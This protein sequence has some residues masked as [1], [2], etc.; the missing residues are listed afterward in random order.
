MIVSAPPPHVKRST[1]QAKGKGQRSQA[2]SRI[3]QLPDRRPAS[4]VADAV[5]S[6]LHE[7]RTPIVAGGDCTIAVGAVSGFLRHDGD[8]ALLYMDGGVDIAT[9]ANYRAGVL[10]STGV[11][12]MVAERGTAEALSR[13][14]PR[15]PL[16]PGERIVPF[17]YTPGEP[18]D[19]ENEI[20][21]RHSI[22]GYP[23]D[24]VRG[25]AGDAAAEALAVLEG[26][27]GGFLVH[28]DVDVID[29]V[30][31]PVADV[32]QINAG[33]TFADAMEALHVFVSS[34]RFG[35]LVITEL[36]PDHAD[37]EGAAGRALVDGVVRA[38]AGTRA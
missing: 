15:F 34:P 12:H 27:T 5:A 31:L 3:R 10:D 7:G 20:L 9:P 8:L 36:S 23:A 24:R 22:D 17:G 1:P 29:F 35:G 26:K 6:T 14:G 25:R 21:G 18:L 30:D 2:R 11:A 37:E 38:L 19:A 4:G 28:F 32:P 33:L 13:I 16:M